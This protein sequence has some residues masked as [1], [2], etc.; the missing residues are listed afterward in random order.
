MYI[1]ND[2][3]KDK[4]K[5]DGYTIKLVPIQKL[6]NVDLYNIKAVYQLVMR[7]FFLTRDV[8]KC[9]SQLQMM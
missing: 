3:Y 2:A 8:C 4:L 6:C 1:G 7:K 9:I 5:L